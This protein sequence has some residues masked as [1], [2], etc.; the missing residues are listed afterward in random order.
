MTEFEIEY[1]SVADA[2]DSVADA[3]DIVQD[4][5]GL[6]RFTAGRNQ[7]DRLIERRSTSPSL[8]Y[9]VFVASCTHTVPHHPHLKFPARRCRLH[10]DG[11]SA[12][13]WIEAGNARWVSM[14]R[15]QS[16]HLKLRRRHVLRRT[17]IQTFLSFSTTKLQ[18]HYPPEDTG[19]TDCNPRRK[20]TSSSADRVDLHRLMSSVLRISLLLAILPLYPFRASST[21]LFCLF[22]ILLVCMSWWE[23]IDRG[24]RSATAS[25]QSC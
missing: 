6:V 4:C 7:T 13:L 16:L 17:D 5:C 8:P 1:N 10:N 2:S 12:A 9:H 11:S 21:C 14:M 25:S 19:R 24:S 15:Q 3:N 18:R 20:R 22:R 23:P